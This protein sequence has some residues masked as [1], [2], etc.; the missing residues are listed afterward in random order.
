LQTK[1]GNHNK[2]SRK[3]A[4]QGQAKQESSKN[5]GKGVSTISNKVFFD[6]KITS[7]IAQIRI[8]VKYLL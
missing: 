4:T 1:N 7:I 2:F 6:F 3:Q 5:N 8:S